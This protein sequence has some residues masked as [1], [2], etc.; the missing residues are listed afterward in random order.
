MLLYIKKAL[1]KKDERG[2]KYVARV[3]ISYGKDKKPRYRYFTTVDAYKTYLEHQG[4]SKD[5]ATKKKKKEPKES[6]KE[7]LLKEKKKKPGPKE[8]PSLFV[9]KK[10]EESND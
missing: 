9:K 4:K 5:G 10:K 2:G 3:P 6:L 8:K 7:K 1:D